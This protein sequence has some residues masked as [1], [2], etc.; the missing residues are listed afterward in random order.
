MTTGGIRV[1]AAEE[2]RVALLH[3]PYSSERLLPM[4]TLQHE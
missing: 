4:Q 2:H 3:C 1:L